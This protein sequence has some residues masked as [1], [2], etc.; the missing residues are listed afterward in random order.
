MLVH[1][2]LWEPAELAQMP[3]GEHQCKRGLFP[4]SHKQ[5]SASKLFELRSGE[6]PRSVCIT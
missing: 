3:A 2:K 5:A 1:I 6:S 4:S